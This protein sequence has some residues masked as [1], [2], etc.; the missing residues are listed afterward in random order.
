[1]ALDQRLCGGVARGAEHARASF[2]SGGLTCAI[3]ALKIAPLRLDD[4]SAGGTIVG[5]VAIMGA[6][7]PEGIHDIGPVGERGHLMIR[8]KDSHTALAHELDS[9]NHDLQMYITQT[10]EVSLIAAS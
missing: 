4:P 10:W 6:P 1:M 7:V 5:A 3:E 2:Q 9:K 8:H